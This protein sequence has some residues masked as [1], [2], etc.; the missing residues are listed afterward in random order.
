[1]S[2]P[3]SK[4]RKLQVNGSNGIQR[5]ESFSDLLMQ[6]EAEEDAGGGTSSISS[7]G[8]HTDVSDNIESD[9]AWPRPAL[10]PS[11]PKKDSISML[12]E[13]WPSE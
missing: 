11:D 7:T 9:K 12:A 13:C 8:G 1:M 5:Q 10:L 2:E 4:K 6:L 3:I